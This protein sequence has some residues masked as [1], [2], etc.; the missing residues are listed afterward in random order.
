MTSYPFGNDPSKIAR[1]RAFW[2]REAAAR[3]LAGFSLVGWFPLNEFSARE[4]W[5]TAGYLTPGMIDIE[6]FLPDHLRMLREG[7]RMGDDLIR[8]ACPGQVAIPWLPGMLGCRL[9]ILPGNVLGEERNLSLDEALR[10]ELDRD[11]PW[12]RKYM[13]FAEALVRAS[14]GT[15]PVSHSAELGPTDLHAVLRGPSASVLDLVDQP[16]RSAELLLKLAGILRDVTEEL[17]RRVPLF[18]GGYFDAQYSLWGP[19]PIV[20][21]QEDATAVYS[22]RLF[23]KFVQ[24]ADRLLAGHFPGNFIHLHSTSMFLLEAFLEIEQIRCYEVNQDALGPPVKAMVPYFRRVQDAR[25]PLLIRGSFSPEEMRLLLDSLDPR[26]LFLSIMVRNER[27][28]EELRP[29]IGM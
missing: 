6:A 26:G 27:E 7:E 1:Y 23:R 21:M 16:E 2:D 29:L 10:V 4:K 22:P 24:P 19:H 13:E 18:H 28:I 17:W 14:G 12:F 15:F 8:G 5:G 11:S 25:K 20:R 9:R 3:P